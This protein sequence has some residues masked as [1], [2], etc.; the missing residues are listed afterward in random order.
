VVCTGGVTLAGPPR[1]MGKEGHHLS[2]QLV[3]HGV[4][5]RAVAFGGGEWADDLAAVEGPIDVAFRPIINSFRGRR[6]VELHL[7]DWR[8]A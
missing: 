3:Q 8:T 2:L 7:V 6:N 1:T 5:L 4:K